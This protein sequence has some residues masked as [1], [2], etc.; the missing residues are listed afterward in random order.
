M[1]TG[2]FAEETNLTYKEENNLVFEIDQ[3][4]SGTGYFTT[5]KHILMPDALGMSGR[6][7]NGVESAGNS[8]GSGIINADAQI[9]AESYYEYEIYEDVEY[10]EEEEPY[11]ELE[12]ADSIINLSEYSNMLYSPR[13]IAIGSRYYAHH[14][15]IFN[16][17]LKDVACIKNRDGLNSINHRVEKAHGLEKAIDIQA[18]YSS[19]MMKVEDNITAGHAHIGVLQLAGIPVDEEDEES[20]IEGEIEVLGLAMKDWKK[21]QIELEED[22]IGTFHMIKNISL[23]TDSWL[24]EEEEAWLPCCTNG[25]EDMLYYDR[26]GFG[27]STKG[28]FD[29][30]CSSAPGGAQSPR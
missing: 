28:V 21:P 25:W 4:V 15:I 20:D 16:S 29:C 27:K 24:M 7:F 26:K 6:L 3:K 1:I 11:E 22:Y 30:T 8:H 5:Y 12:D 23:I 2:G 13:S 9:Y 17:L 10:D 14:P 19:T 18:D